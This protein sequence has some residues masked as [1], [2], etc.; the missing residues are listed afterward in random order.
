MSDVE[1]SQSGLASGMVN[2]SFMMGGALGLAILASLAAGQTGELVAAGVDEAAA[3]N[4]GYHAAFWV[5]AVFAFG[6]A[7]LGAAFIR[8]GAHGPGTEGMA[9]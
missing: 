9:H 7:A 6:A 5:G 2:T 1:P 8:T 3:L 4:A